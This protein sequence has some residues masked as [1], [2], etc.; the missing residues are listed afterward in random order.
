MKLISEGKK[1]SRT[2]CK[3]IEKHKK[4][5]FIVAWA[6]AETEVM[7]TII[8]NQKKIK[9][10]VIGI[11]F[12]QTDSAVLESFI[13]SNKVKFMLQTSGVFHP[14]AYIFWTN[15]EWDIII[16]S[17]NLTHGAFT[18]NK[19]LCVHIT[20]KD[21]DIEIYDELI[22]EINTIWNE[23]E[24]LNKEKADNYKK[25]KEKNQKKIYQ[26]AGIYGELENS[27]SPLQSSIMS[28][29]WKKYFKNVMKDKYHVA[30][31]R[32]E[33][34]EIAHNLFVNK[35]LKDMNI[36]ERKAIAGLDSDYMNH[37]DWGWFG[38]MKPM[39]KFMKK[40]TDN[41][42]HFS[43][44]LDMIPLTGDI[45]YSDYI[46]A[47]NEFLKA[48]PDQGDGLGTFTRLLSM[49]RPDYFICI[50]AKNKENLCNDL[51]ILKSKFT[52]TYGDIYE[53][54]W[55]ELILRILDSLWW[56]SPYPEKELEQRVWKGRVAMLDSI[57]YEG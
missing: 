28:M 45:F 57:F 41:N 23:G 46:N 12:Y 48:Y 31:E 10:G 49:K 18:K 14:K 5:S 39:G 17:A 20:S 52:K 25:L 22:K 4:F 11:H 42:I 16:G 26:L 1:L 21:T 54:Y 40:I 2:I 9:Y 19:E 6:S 50:N 32:C 33:L 3:L 47:K 56:S 53:N 44:M 51:G 38:S 7:N 35:S 27:K 55:N 30:E 34:L 29:N 24:I 13:N 43:N 8:D 37:T 15:D 36:N